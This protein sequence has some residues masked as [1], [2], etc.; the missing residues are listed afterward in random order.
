[1]SGKYVLSG[2]G[3]HTLKLWDISSIKFGSPSLNEISKNV[4]KRRYHR[5]YITNTSTAL[6]MRNRNLKR[7][8]NNNTS[9]DDNDDNDTNTDDD[10]DDDDEND[11]ND[12]EEYED[13]ISNGRNGER[14]DLSRKGPAAILTLKGHFGG[15]SSVD[16]EYP[17]SVSGS[18][19]KT[20]RYWDLERGQEINCLRSERWIHEDRLESFS[21]GISSS[22]SLDLN[23]SPNH[24][25]NHHDDDD[26]ESNSASVWSAYGVLPSTTRSTTLS[27]SNLS[28]NLD[29][30]YKGDLEG[31]GMTDIRGWKPNQESK[32]FKS[33]SISSQQPQR[34]MDVGGHVAAVQMR[35]HALAGGYGDG[36]VR[37]WDL[38][39]GKCHREFAGH[40]G[41]VTCLQFDE[42]CVIT[43]GVDKTVKLWDLRNGNISSDLSLPYS[44][45]SL[46]FDI[47]QIAIAGGTEVQILTR[48]LGI[49]AGL[50]LGEHGARRLLGHPKA[51]RCVGIGVGTT[52]RGERLVSGGMEG[53]V[54]VYRI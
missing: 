17:F 11:E 25:P 7:G 21:D 39:S 20:I 23:V 47:S 6:T 53:T 3:D 43:G 42:R 22:S 27:S 50:G 31:F 26:R 13:D 2:S 15:I 44:I 52:T 41:A 36:I 51:V 35:E 9:D 18:S 33:L 24:H 1:M 54:R 37:L 19:D 10:N 5:G 45:T 34:L 16:I 38:R 32:S 12:H 40:L 46:Q 28:N 49:G 4:V 8:V 30:H 29:D 48:G 14:M